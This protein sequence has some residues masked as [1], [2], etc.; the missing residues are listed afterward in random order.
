MRAV[1][2]LHQ[3]SLLIAACLIFKYSKDRTDVMVY[4]VHLDHLVYLDEI[5][6]VGTIEDKARKESQDQ[7]LE[8]WCL[9]DGVEASV[10]QL[11]I[12]NCSTKGKLL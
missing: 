2:L 1:N 7:E 6:A 11:M 4:Q 3:R 5:I 9:L 8:V 10:L 12:Q